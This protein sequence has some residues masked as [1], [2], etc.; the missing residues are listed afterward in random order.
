MKS[1]KGQLLKNLEAELEKTKRSECDGQTGRSGAHHQQGQGK[2]QALRESMANVEFYELNCI[3]VTQEPARM[4][5]GVNS[6][7]KRIPV[8]SLPVQRTQ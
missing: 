8:P 4:Q 3:L 7:E 6:R 5:R 1:R 2:V